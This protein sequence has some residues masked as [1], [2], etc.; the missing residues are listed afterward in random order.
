MPLKLL[1]RNPQAALIISNSIGSIIVTAV[2]FNAPLYYQAVQLES[3]TASGLHLVVPYIGASVFGTATGFAITYTRRL[4]WPPLTG[5][6][7]LLIGCTGLSTMSPTSP[8]WL[9]SAS[10]IFFGAGQGFLFP[11]VFV[12]VLAVSEQAEQ[13]VVT[14]TLILWRSLG[15]VL[16]VASSSLVVQ[17]ALRINLDRMVVGPDREDVI[18]KVRKSVAA[19][20][21][22]EEPYKTQVIGAYAQSLRA[23]FILTAVCAA[24]AFCVVVPLKMPMLKKREKR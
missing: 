19:I 9:P 20:S 8:S 16:G 21:G 3:A 13:A 11:G 1:T 5:S 14:S 12:A 10:L 24:L 2:M 6:L 15:N 4:K 23:A 18:D 22:L 7:L 17:N